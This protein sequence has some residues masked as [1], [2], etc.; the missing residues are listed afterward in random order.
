MNK[1][2]TADVNVILLR[3]KVTRNVINRN[4]TF[5]EFLKRQYS[6][7]ICR[8]IRKLHGRAIFL[9]QFVKKHRLL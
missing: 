8:L 9:R 1:I 2:I 4:N 7:N 3:A 5:D 6:V